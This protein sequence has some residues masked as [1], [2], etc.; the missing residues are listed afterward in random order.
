MQL[1]GGDADLGTEAIFKAICKA[2]RGVHH[3]GAGIDFAQETHRAGMVFGNDCVGVLRAIL[4]D[5]GDCLVDPRHG[6]DRHDRCQVLGV[7]IFFSRV[8]E[9]CD[10]RRLE[11]GA[12]LCVAT[13]F[14]ALVGINSPDQGQHLGRYRLCHQQRLHRIARRIALRLGVVG[15]AYRFVDIGFAIDVDMTNTVEVFDHRHP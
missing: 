10:S 7:K 15:D 5:M 14:N 6:R 12:A 9:I 2:G 4:G 3:D 13:H 11:D 1:V 8:F